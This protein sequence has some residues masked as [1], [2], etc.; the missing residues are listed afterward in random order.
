[1]KTE[2][3]LTS[4][5]RL[6]GAF[7]ISDERLTYFA[8]SGVLAIGAIFLLWIFWNAF[9]AIPSADDFCY[10]FGARSRGV[11]Q[12]VVTEY[13]TWG[14]R[15]TPAFLIGAF[16][17]SD[18]VLLRH[19]YVVP[20][21]I[22]ALN[23]MAAR[24]FLSV[25]GIKSGAFV[26]LFFVMLM[27]TFRMRESLFWLAG[28]ATY[29]VSCALFLTLIAEELRIFRG[30]LVISK[31]RIAL[32]SLASVFLASFNE[33][34]MLAHI[35]LLFPLTIYCISQKANKAVVFILVAAI[36]GAIISAAAPGN[37]LR[38]AT[39]PQHINVLLAAW[40]A[41]RLILLKYVASFLVSLLLFY[42][43]FAIIRPRKE[44]EFSRR[45]IFGFSTFL[46][47]A[48]WAS[49]FARTFVLNDLGPERARTIDYMLVNVLAFLIAT[50]LHTQRRAINMAKRKSVM[51]GTLFV[52]TV[53]LIM[54]FIFLPNHTWRPIV[55][56]IAASAELKSVMSARFDAAKQ[57]KGKVLE[58]A[59]YTK[60][61]KPITFFNEIK[62]NPKE[63]ENVCF[64][65]YFEL[66]EV[67]LKP[68]PE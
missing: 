61:P 7:D 49:I 64:A 12:N 67:R 39:M 32:L 3:A 29:G 14:G 28:G 47:L 30:N 17:V 21:L 6:N 38:A 53:A 57:A 51:A 20:L 52:G 26:L 16:A 33:T 44:I 42:C 31:K 50:H 60:E 22:L 54:S 13:L 40:S 66:T 4:R 48:L 63:W 35:A 34:V 62:T 45:F 59:G 36:I 9:H 18:Q 58:A 5:T 41:L 43:F 23:F 46:F 37:F 19:Y 8:R 56:G 15:Y 11:F 2:E 55:T 27:A 25:A 68:K 1:M 24:H 65:Q 10:G